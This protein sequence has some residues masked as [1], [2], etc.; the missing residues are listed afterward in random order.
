M[1][2][3]EM[4]AQTLTRDLFMMK[5]VLEDLNEADL[6][7]RPVAGANHPIWQ[8]GHLVLAEANLV[9]GAQAG[10]VPP[11]PAVFVEKF[12]KDNCK[13]DDP[14]FFPKK[15]EILDVMTNG[16]NATVAWV[17]SLS[18]ADL[19][20]AITGPTARFADSIGLMLVN[21]PWHG[22]MHVG[23][24]QVLRRKLGKPVLM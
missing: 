9:N 5:R 10:A 14:S 2:A 12:K 4:I 22:A 21:L 20:R 23:Q 11:P 15:A 7:T 6:M 3:V 17:K 18:P 19:D 24:I 16:R 13:I 1:P 8:L